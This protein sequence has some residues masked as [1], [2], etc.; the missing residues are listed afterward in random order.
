MVADNPPGRSAT[1][2]H[3][4]AKARVTFDRALSFGQHVANITAEA[5]GRCRVLTSLTS[6]QWGWRKDQLTKIYKALYLSVLKYGDPAWQPWLAATHL[7]PL[8]SCA[9][10]SASE[11]EGCSMMRRPPSP[12]SLLP[13]SSLPSLSDPAG[14]RP[15]KA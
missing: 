5:A 2:L 1:A 7:E 13:R 14:A 8:T 12:A 9:N 4:S 10:S 11:A 15:P 3:F 6:K